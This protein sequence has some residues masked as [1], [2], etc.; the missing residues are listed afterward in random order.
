MSP[1]P[2]PDLRGQVVVITGGNSGIGREAAV[3]LASMGA[4][5][6]ITARSPSKGE[7]ARAEVRARSGNPDVELLA[8][9][10][11]DF[12]S[13]RTA[14]TEVLERFDRLDVL[15]NNA[16]G[17]ISERALTAQGF[18][19]TFGVN[20]LGHFLLT[21]LLRDRLVRSAPSRV[22]TV[23]SLAH[24]LAVR[25]LAFDDLQSER[26]Y[27]S[28]NAYAKSKLANLMFSNELARRLVGTGV[29]SN[30]L[31][32]GSVR[33]GFGRSDR[34]SAIDRAT[35]IVGAPF[36]RSPKGGSRTSVYLASSPEVAGATG[37]YYVRRKPHRPSK[38][39][40]DEAAA[41]RLWD[42]SE[43]LVAEAGA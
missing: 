32:P 23:S 1:I 4:A 12:A 13:I 24:R 41:R 38:H 15:V 43:A 34:A 6:A 31:H 18:E 35:M 19:M 28:M 36:L 10:L 27:G 17:I 21:D 26:R 33:T 14:A 42:E 9:D 30:A 40:R 29:T 7:A 16:G 2:V 5:V 11:A 8:L 25:G 22:V 20:H 3:S 39:A 37:G